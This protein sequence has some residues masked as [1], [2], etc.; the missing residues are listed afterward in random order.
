MILPHYSREFGKDRID[1]FF[2]ELLVE[3]FKEKIEKNLEKSA[4]RNGRSK[5]QNFR[6]LISKV[7]SPD[8]SKIKIGVNSA[9]LAAKGITAGVSGAISLGP[10]GTTDKCL[11]S[12]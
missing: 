4:A 8:P 3:I 2:V 7:V 9:V 1:T 10:I 12:H 11:F 6:H 5:S